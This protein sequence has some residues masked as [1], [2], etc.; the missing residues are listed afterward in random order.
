MN[1]YVV[2]QMS[3]S[4]YQ[5]SIFRK[6]I[7]FAVGLVCLC[8]TSLAEEAIVPQELRV[9]KTVG[10][11]E[12][13][14]HLFYPQGHKV[15]DSRPAIVFFFGGGWT[16]GT[17]RQFYQHSRDFAANGF[18]AIAAEYRVAKRHG[19]TP[20]DCVEDGKSAVRWIRAQAASLGIDPKRIVAAGGSAGGHV[21]ACTALVD[22]LDAAGEDLS[23]SSRPRA[24]ILYNPVLDTT[25]S[26]YG[27]EKVG[28][29]RKTEISP[30]HLVRPGLPPT[31][32]IHGTADKTV[33]FENAE[34]FTRE[35]QAA[36]NTCEL[37]AVEGERHGFFNGSYFRPKN[38]DEHHN[39]T[40][41]QSLEFLSRVFCGD[42]G[43]KP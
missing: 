41:Q 7:A 22:G 37:I 32:V 18:V 3:D 16:G 8:E 33:P 19:A 11:D 36:G 20:F 6:V 30:C 27:V 1:D 26:G 31:L 24:L 43:A 25:E 14:L 40:V 15:T 5:K 42:A 35:M 13:K 9:F 2:F 21:A 28:Q 17:P 39:R 38:S 12:L 4:V 10:A 29:A 34:R 23:V